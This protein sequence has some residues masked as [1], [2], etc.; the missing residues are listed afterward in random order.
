MDQRGLKVDEQILKV[1]KF[2]YIQ[3]KGGRYC[4]K[5]Y[6][7]YDPQNLRLTLNR[8]HLENCS[9]FRMNRENPHPPAPSANIAR[10]GAK[11]KSLSQV[12]R[13]I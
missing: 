7:E 1:E 4:P 12:G 13:G 5:I 2:S 11:N 9:S 3:P 8:V 10:R 6:A